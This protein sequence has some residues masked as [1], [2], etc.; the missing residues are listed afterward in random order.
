MRIDYED[1]DQT[2]ELLLPLAD[3]KSTMCAL[4]PSRLRSLLVPYLGSFDA[5]TSFEGTSFASLTER[6]KGERIRKIFILPRS[7]VG[8]LQAGVGVDW[9]ENKACVEG[10]PDLWELVATLRKWGK[11]GAKELKALYAI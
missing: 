2:V 7:R 11:A 6:G 4:L 9:E 1:F 10:L 5:S 3:V 8:G